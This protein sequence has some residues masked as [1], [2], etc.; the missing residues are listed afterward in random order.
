[1]VCAGTT[2]IP[3]AEEAFA[4]AHVVGA[5]VWSGST[6]WDLRIAPAAAE[7]S[8][9][10]QADA[11][12]VCA[13]MEGALLRWWVDCRA[14]PVDR[15]ATSVG[16]GLPGGIAALLADAQL[17]RAQRERGHIDN[18]SARGRRGAIARQAHAAGRTREA[19]RT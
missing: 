13:G 4:T 5:Q 17:L 14:A 16:Y 3:V 12:V 9:L 2:D 18:G 6:T 15:G 8:G 1:V 10:R 11:L 7:R 19:R